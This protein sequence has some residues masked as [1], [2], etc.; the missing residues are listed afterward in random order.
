MYPHESYPA[1]PFIP[2][3]LTSAL[4]FTTLQMC[5][6]AISEVEYEKFSC[7]G[8]LLWG[9]VG[10][11]CQHRNT[12][13]MFR[14][15]DRCSDIF[16]VK[17]RLIKSIIGW[18]NLRFY[19]YFYGWCSCPAGSYLTLAFLSKCVWEIKYR[20][21]NNNIWKADLSQLKNRILKY[22]LLIKS[23]LY[24]I[25]HLIRSCFFLL[26]PCLKRSHQ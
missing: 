11:S 15:T 6:V 21:V 4:N 25:Y 7:G 12:A 18:F 23:Y 17:I 8:S 10:F 5:L 13:L 24:F 14:V 16:L 20:F 26:V 1:W 19:W 9:N 2:W 22:I 3:V